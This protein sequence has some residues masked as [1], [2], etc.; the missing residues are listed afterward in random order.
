MKKTKWFPAYVNPVHIGYY[1]TS[2]TLFSGEPHRLYWD[3]RCWTK[4]E[5]SKVYA[6]FPWTGDRWRGLTEPAA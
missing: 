2:I 4:S 3:G 1:E 6:P 5:T